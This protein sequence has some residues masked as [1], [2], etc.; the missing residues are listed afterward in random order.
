[1]HPGNSWQSCRPLVLSCWTQALGCSKALTCHVLMRLRTQTRVHIHRQAEQL[2]ERCQGTEQQDNDTSSLHS[3]NCS[4]QEIW[5]QCFKI[6]HAGLPIKR[7]ACVQ[8]QSTMMTVSSCA[9]LEHAHAK[10]VS[11]DLVGVVIETV[12]DVCRGHEE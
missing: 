11:Q 10:C 2:C 3:L 7:K 6:L 9:H 12:S 5:R 8:F 1:M 4:C